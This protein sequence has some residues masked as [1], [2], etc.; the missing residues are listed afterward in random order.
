MRKIIASIDF[1]SDTIKIVVGEFIKDKF[2]VLAAI[3]HQSKGIKKGVIVDLDATTSSLQEALKEIETR[4][5][6]EV[7]KVILNIPSYYANF[8][9]GR[10]QT[11][12]SNETGF[13]SG[14]DIVRAIQGSVYNQIPENMELINVVPVEFTIDDSER[15]ENP[16]SMTAKKLGVKTVLITTPKKNVYPVLNVIENLGLQ[17]SDIILGSMSD[18]YTFNNPEMDKVSGVI[19]NVG[20]E[21][22]SVSIFNKGII[23][24]TEILEIGNVNIDNDISFIY[25][26]NSNDAKIL[27]ENLAL[28]HI[29]NADA[30]HFEEVTNKLNE[31]IKI[32]QY[33]I[34]EIVASRVDEI[35]KLAKKQI[36]LLT[37]KEISYIIITG[38]ITELKDF[39][40]TV[41]SIFGKSAT[42]GLMNTLGVRS[43]IFSCSL[44]M[45][46]FF[47]NKM[48]MRNKD[49]CI[50]NDIQ[51]E[52]LSGEGK[53]INIDNDSI[54]GKIF[55]Y[56]FD[57]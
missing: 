17:A 57:N 18:Y 55:G 7:K 19:I 10:G 3:S 52:D 22:T 6:L 36:N 2:L 42:V 27:K 9:L 46:N 15:V 21:T 41:E 26:V 14:N 13:V 49:Y 40:L 1:G 34:T 28:S 29:R 11:T 35:L 30:A 43:G 38:G 5:G 48:K 20:H 33:E 16:M 56:F 47:N 45:I 44:G 50:F 25:K 39:S 37:K 23:V 53:K 54:L 12:I 24:N 8:E 31:N 32:N 51:L 4:I